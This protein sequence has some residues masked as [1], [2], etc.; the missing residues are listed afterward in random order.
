MATTTL[1]EAREDIGSRSRDGDDD[2]GGG[3]R[4]RRL[5]LL[6]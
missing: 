4:R 6:A 3:A 2:T 1:A 5:H